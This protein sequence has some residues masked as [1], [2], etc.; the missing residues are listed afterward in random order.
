[1]AREIRQIHPD[2]MYLLEFKRPELIELYIGLR[3]FVLNIYPDCNEMV[4]HTHALTSVYSISEKLADAF[5]TLPIYTDHVNLGL[6][7]GT[8]L[9][10]PHKLLRGTGNL[11]RHIPV[12]QRSDYRN[13]AV[14]DIVKAAAELAI[15]EMEKPTTSIR[16]TI[17]KIK[18][19]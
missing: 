17:S 12:E 3:E 15:T 8:L 13:D 5:C 4:Y 14:R 10:D 2:F 16:K 1:M 7:K 11:M 9:P 6:N 19:K 18:T